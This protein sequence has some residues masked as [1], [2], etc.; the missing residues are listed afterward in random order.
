M[1]KES[2]N[3]SIFFALKISE[4]S[5]VPVYL[6]GNPGCG[7]STSV[8]MFAKIRGYELITLRGS[9]ST[10]SEILGFDAVH[11]RVEDIR[12]MHCRPTWFEQLL[13]YDRQG[14]KVILFLDE[15]SSSTQ[16]IQSA[17]LN[18]IFDRKVD[19]ERIP[20]STLIV[21][22]GNYINNMGAEFQTLSALYNRFCIFNVTVDE[23]ALDEFLSR[24]DGVAT[25]KQGSVI[26]QKSAILE[27]MDRLGVEVS[28]DKRAKICQYFEVAVKETS[29][30]LLKGNHVLDFNCSETQSI[31]NTMDG[32]ETLKGFISLRTLGYLVRNAIET[33][34]NFGKDGIK[35][36]N[37]KK[38]IE[39][40]CGVALSRQ[41][42]EVVKTVVS[43]NF[44]NSLVQTLSS[45]DKLSND[46]IKVY[47]EFF[48]KMAVTK[49]EMSQEEVVA[50]LGKLEEMANDNEIKT[51]SKPLEDVIIRN[52]SEMIKYNSK[53]SISIKLKTTDSVAKVLTPEFLTGTIATWNN[54][55]ELYSR[56]NRIVMNKNNTYSAEIIKVMETT[57]EKLTEDFMKLGSYSKLVSSNYPEFAG[58]LPQIK[59]PKQ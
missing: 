5:G 55:S 9:T 26:D 24:Y 23:S 30:S 41:N 28:A 25:G 8:E 17:L 47:E 35:S 20:D 58:L 59:N 39:G 15:L 44:Y 50:I 52:L 1:K 42:G 14:K 22:A 38:I 36:D 13:E 10:E 27:S 31:Y 53:K 16:Y 32:D 21:A 3:S 29:R 4:K 45:I 2:I 56:V 11:N 57:K 37:F 51:V 40:L 19:A 43:E 48:E 34:F 18:L 33:Y 7:K 12:V 46:R 49:K 6:C 54:I